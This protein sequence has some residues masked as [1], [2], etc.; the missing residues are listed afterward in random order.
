MMA[1]LTNRYLHRGF[2]V[3][4]LI[5]CLQALPDEG[6]AQAQDQQELDHDEYH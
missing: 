2:P 4:V 5:D 1:P 6:A 3:F